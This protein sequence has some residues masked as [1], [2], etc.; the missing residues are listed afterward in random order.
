LL[1]K[2]YRDLCAY[3]EQKGALEYDER[4]VASSG[5]R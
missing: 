2:L 3:R 5:K 4:K 1:T